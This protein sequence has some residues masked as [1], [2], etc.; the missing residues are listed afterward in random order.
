[1]EDRIQ[2]RRRR[3]HSLVLAHSL[4]DRKAGGGGTGR[5]NAPSKGHFPGIDDP[6][7]WRAVGYGA[8]IS[9]LFLEAYAGVA[10]V[11]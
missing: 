2:W 6:A 3:I 8:D 7:R 4:A 11:G 5:R 10:A 1:M 9:L